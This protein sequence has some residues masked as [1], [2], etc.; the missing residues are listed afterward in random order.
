MSREQLSRESHTAQMLRFQMLCGKKHYA[1][2][3]NC[4][5]AKLIVAGIPCYAGWSDA[6]DCMNTCCLT[7]VVSIVYQ[8]HQT[9]NVKV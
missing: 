6:F 2:R 9:D 4:D 1:I 8:G 5:E 3:P 7:M